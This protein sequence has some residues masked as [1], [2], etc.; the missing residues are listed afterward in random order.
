MGILF[1]T[2][3]KNADETKVQLFF[4]GKSIET[5]TREELLEALI[6]LHHTHESSLRENVECRNFL[7]DAMKARG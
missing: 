2:A 7:L 4:K 5:L 1:D 3:K 6:Y